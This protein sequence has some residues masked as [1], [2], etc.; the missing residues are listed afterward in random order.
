[1]HTHT[2]GAAECRPMLADAEPNARPVNAIED[3]GQPAPRTRV[4]NTTEDRSAAGVECCPADLDTRQDEQVAAVAPATCNTNHDG[5][6]RVAQERHYRIP[7]HHEIRST[8]E[9]Q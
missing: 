5:H 4:M 6:G 8:Y 2:D 1:M 9:K 3:S 7:D